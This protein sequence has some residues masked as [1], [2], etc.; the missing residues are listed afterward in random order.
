M[1]LTKLK[2]GDRLFRVW[3]ASWVNGTTEIHSVTIKKITAK[4]VW[5][6]KTGDLAFQCRTGIEPEAAQQCARTPE[7]AIAK[8]EV[9]L[10]EAARLAQVRLDAFRAWVARGGGTEEAR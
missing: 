8:Y 7:A 3:A 6:T 2:P 10:E 5:F 4:K 9:R 1:T